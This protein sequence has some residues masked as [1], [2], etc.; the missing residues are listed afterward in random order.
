MSLLVSLRIEMAIDY[1]VKLMRASTHKRFR[2]EDFWE[3]K[4]PRTR[5]GN[6]LLFRTLETAM[7][8]TEHLQASNGF[9]LHQKGQKG[10]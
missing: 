3:L 4:R 7:R 8:S 9:K 6:V 5:A 10:A 2:A 1:R